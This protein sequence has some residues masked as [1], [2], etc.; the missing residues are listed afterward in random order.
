MTSHLDTPV[1]NAGNLSAESASQQDERVL[2]TQVARLITGSGFSNLAGISMAIIWVGLIWKDLPHEV[3]SVWLGLMLLL[4]FYRFATHYFKLYSDESKLSIDKYIIRRWYLVSVFLTGAGWGVTSTLMFPF[5]ELHQ[6]VLAFILVGVSASGVTYSSV[7]WVYYGYVGC[8]LLPLM[9]RLFYVGGEVYYALSAMTGFFLGVMVMAVYRMYKSSIA[10]LE[11]SYKN[12]ALID[13]LT[14]A[15]DNLEILNDDL[16]TEIQH[17]KQIELEL[18]KAK[19]KAEKM[20]QAKGE[21]LAN[22][23][24]EIRTPMNGVIGTL[25]LL[26][27]TNLNEEQKEFVE[28][29]HKSA[30]ALLAILNDILDLSKI[31]AGK[32]SFENIAFDFKQIVKDIVI[33]HSLKAEQKGVFLVQQVDESLPELLMGDPTRLRQ[34]IVNLVSN[35]LKFTRQGE[36]KIIVDVVN[37]SAD[38]VDLKIA[39]IDTGIG[40]PQAAQDTLFNAFTQ[41]DGS[42]TRK[43][44]GTGLGLAIV[45]QLIDL[46]GGSL[47]VD[48][49]E[50]DGSEFWFTVSLQCA[51]QAH[52]VVGEIANK[53]K[54]LQFD[55]KIL[56]V[57]DNPINQMVAQKMLEKVGVK[58]ILANNGVEALKLLNEQ[59]FDLVLMDCQMPEMDGFDATREIRKLDIM[60]LKQQPLPIVAMTA[61]VMSGDRE[62]CLEVGMDDYIGKPVQRDQLASVLNK[63]LV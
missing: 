58:P 1:L 19:E 29:A 52:E 20:S 8:V 39:V 31:E 44:G 22:M 16:K 13:D 47:G 5:N 28:I 63:W 9:I 6:I 61:N 40:I 25:Q 48:S 42:T 38:S 15:S 10:E 12:E 55:A 2:R 17:G 41:A 46:M 33:L 36:V 57:E 3:L 34:V 21:F 62:R 43:Y 11:L 30:D 23:S 50:G 45:S 14:K 27:D 26:D 35:A 7:A 54:A 18:K 53:T 51:E 56:L 37:K 24:H 4:F 49:V 32:L 60:A 59:S